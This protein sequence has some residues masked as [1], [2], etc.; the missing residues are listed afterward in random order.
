MAYSNNGTR[1]SGSAPVAS[2][3][4]SS[5]LTYQTVELSLGSFTRNQVTQLAFYVNGSTFGTGNHLF[6]IDNISIK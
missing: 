5:S 4:V 2:F 6:Y 3:Q 1:V